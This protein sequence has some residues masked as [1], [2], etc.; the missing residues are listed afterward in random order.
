MSIR[1]ILARGPTKGRD[2]DGESHE[3][4]FVMARSEATRPSISNFFGWIAAPSR[5]AGWLAMTNS[6]V[7]SRR[8]TA[9]WRAL[10]IRFPRALAQRLALGPE[11]VERASELAH[12]RSQLHRLSALSSF[13]RKP[14]MDTNGHE[15]RGSR[16]SGTN[17]TET[18]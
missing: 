10:R 17:H 15:C 1:V 16:G 12:N 4:G 14:Q 8:G 3:Q 13:S 5:R 18:F 2:L 6:E 11:L 7:G 9:R